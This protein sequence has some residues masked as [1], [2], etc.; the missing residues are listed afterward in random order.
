MGP[1]LKPLQ[2]LHRFW[3]NI[4][5]MDFKSRCTLQ[6]SRGLLKMISA[7]GSMT[8]YVDWVDLGGIQGIHERPKLSGDYAENHWSEWS[9]P[10]T[11]Y[12]QRRIRE[13]CVAPFQNFLSWW[14]FPP[15]PVPQ[16]EYQ[17]LSSSLSSL[18]PSA[19]LINQPHWLWHPRY[20]SSVL[21]PPVQ[22]L[23][24]VQ[25]FFISLEPIRMATLQMI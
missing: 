6:A 13:R 25:D 17:A 9:R 5:L 8:R 15:S 21:C 10:K 3:S 19:R 18:C 24:L 16:A 22:L 23:L 1:H 4:P 7:F 2:L 12:K 20:H 14:S 11:Y